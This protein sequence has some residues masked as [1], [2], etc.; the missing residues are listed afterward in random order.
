[1]PAATAIV[2]LSSSK[3]AIAFSPPPPLALRPPPEIAERGN[4]SIGMYAPYEL[5]PTIENPRLSVV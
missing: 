2:I 3:Y 5:T 4:R 1:M